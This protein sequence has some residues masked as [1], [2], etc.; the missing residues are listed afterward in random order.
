M[1]TRILMSSSAVIMALAGMFFSFFP[2]EL[3]QYL[4][5][6]SS[7]FLPLILQLTGALY[8]GFALLNWMAKGNL[9]GGIYSRPI[10]I[11]NLMHF[12]V[13]T[14]AIGKYYFAHQRP[15]VLII[16]V[17]IYALFSVLFGKV[18]FGSPVK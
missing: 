8:L 16:P 9:M 4:G 15:T 12:M 13:F 18:V 7:A 14:L 3:L 11:G 5:V 2:D 1:N 17:L 6:G 10:A